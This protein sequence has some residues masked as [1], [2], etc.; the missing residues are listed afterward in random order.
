MSENSVEVYSAG[1]WLD[2]E[3]A[4]GRQSP[5]NEVLFECHC[6][7]G[8]GTVESRQVSEQQVSLILTVVAVVPSQTNTNYTPVA[9]K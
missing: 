9:G 7:L 3:L 2:V 1:Q 6:H 4:A 8:S 5:R